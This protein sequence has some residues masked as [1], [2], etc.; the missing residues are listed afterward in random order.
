MSTDGALNLCPQ[1]PLHFQQGCHWL[2]QSCH[3]FCYFHCHVSGAWCHMN[4]SPA[5]PVTAFAMP[6]ASATATGRS[7][8][9]LCP[10]VERSAIFWLIDSLI[11]W[12]FIIT[13]KFWEAWWD[14]HIS[15]HV[16]LLAPNSDKHLISPYSITSWSNVQ[17]MRLKKVIT[18]DKNVLMF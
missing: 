14:L 1:H 15:Q 8:T 3:D 13:W 2:E 5:F 12:L 11:K 7:L 10:T 6:T 16:T 17:V 4:L 18:K 9:R